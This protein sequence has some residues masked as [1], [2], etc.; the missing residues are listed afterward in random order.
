M[1]DER[2]SFNISGITLDIRLFELNFHVNDTIRDI[3]QLIFQRSGLLVN[4]QRILYADGGSTMILADSQTISSYNI[5][6][7]VTL[8]IIIRPILTEGKGLFFDV[9]Y[10][11]THSMYPCLEDSPASLRKGLEKK[12]EI[13]ISEQIIIIEGQ[14][15]PFDAETLSE[16]NLNPDNAATLQLMIQRRSRAKSARK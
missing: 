10:G 9:V 4:S 13:P 3:K 16:F 5:K 7:Q 11:D 6:N 14:E 12:L 2:V 1:V 15:I 8:Q